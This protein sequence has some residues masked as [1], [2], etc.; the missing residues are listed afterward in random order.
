[1]VLLLSQ[2]FLRL[3]LKSSWYF[4]KTKFF[5]LLTAF[6]NINNINIVYINTKLFIITI[7]M[8][9]SIHF[10]PNF[11]SGYLWRSWPRNFTGWRKLS[12]YFNTASLPFSSSH[13][14]HQSSTVPGIASFQKVIRVF[15]AFIICI[16]TNLKFPIIYPFPSWGRLHP[17]MQLLSFIL[18]WIILFFPV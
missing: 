12:I 3:L 1:M 14:M 2:L 4:V 8:N 11:R 7:N 10:F 5:H 18:I 6:F 16:L 9:S 15:I 17:G 13:N